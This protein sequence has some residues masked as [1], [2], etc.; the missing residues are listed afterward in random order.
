MGRVWGWGGGI[1]FVYSQAAVNQ[2]TRKEGPGRQ[3][4]LMKTSSA[5][6]VPAVP[7]RATAPPFCAAIWSTLSVEVLGG[8]VRVQ[9]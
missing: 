9:Q 3:K 2:T 7:E 6:L 8:V 1:C 4:P 5:T